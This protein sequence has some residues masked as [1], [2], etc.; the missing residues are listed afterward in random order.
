MASV[1][2]EIRQHIA[3]SDARYGPFASTH[4]AL[5]VACEEWDELRAAIH[6]N[7]LA[8]VEEECIDLAAVL[9]RLAED[10]RGNLYIKDRSIR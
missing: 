2:D 3:A 6:S 9:I 8:S 1:L 10:L 7:K 5:G 4:E